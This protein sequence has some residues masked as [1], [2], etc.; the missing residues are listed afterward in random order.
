M[1][2][3]PRVTITG[4]VDRGANKVLVDGVEISNVVKEVRIVID[5]NGPRVSL[6]VYT[7]K[8]DV[9]TDVAE[10][11][12]ALLLPLPGQEVASDG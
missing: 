5:H 3:G 12:Q 8:V 9:E 7:C 1:T 10:A 11:V 2:T 4:G 6:D